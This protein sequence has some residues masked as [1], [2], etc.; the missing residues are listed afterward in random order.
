MSSIVLESK[1]SS[2]MKAGHFDKR[3]LLAHQQ[4]LSAGNSNV[5][6]ARRRRYV[7][8]AAPGVG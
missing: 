5:M 6:F 1:E 7:D 8:V 2:L 4:T 3:I